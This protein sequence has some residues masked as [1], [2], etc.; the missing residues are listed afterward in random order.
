MIAENAIP[1]LN[2]N[3][4]SLKGKSLS[5]AAFLPEDFIKVVPLAILSRL[6]L[7]SIIPVVIPC[8]YGSTRSQSLSQAGKFSSGGYGFISQ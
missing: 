7:V 6:I 4:S 1:C 8:S 3:L 2:D 5:L